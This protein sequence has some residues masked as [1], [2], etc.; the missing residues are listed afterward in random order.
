MFLIDWIPAS[1]FIPALLAGL[2]VLIA[3]PF[4]FMF[5][6]IAPYK[7]PVNALAILVV[8]GSV[9]MHGVTTTK[10]EWEQ[11]LQATQT[12]LQQAR[13]EVQSAK[14]N[15]IV[16]ERVVTKIQ[17]IKDKTNENVRIIEK[18]V[19]VIDA[20]CKLPDAAVVLVD[21][22]SKAE[23][24]RSPTETPRAA[25]PIEASDVLKTVIENYG[26]CNE[27]IEIIKGWQDWYWTQKRIY[28]QK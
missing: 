13:L 17:Y 20:N 10:Q 14:E 28:E 7:L 2:F 24:A 6:V 26:I 1:Y 19:P 11:K 12:E 25:D 8:V 23:V 21:S 9:W 18:L 16:E 27:H 22:A 3:S 5:P 15:I 4:I